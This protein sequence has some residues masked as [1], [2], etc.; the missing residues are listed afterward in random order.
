MQRI[1]KFQSQ[2]NLYLPTYPDKR[3]AYVVLEWDYN[4]HILDGFIRNLIHGKVHED[5]VRHHQI[6]ENDIAY[7]SDI[8]NFLIPNN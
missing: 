3:F 2:Q 7:L 4:E 6:P 8:H 5:V 1:K